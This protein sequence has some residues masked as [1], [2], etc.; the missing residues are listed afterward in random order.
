[1]KQVRIYTSDYE[2]NDFPEASHYPEYVAGRAVALL[3]ENG[4]A[5]EVDVEP[6]RPTRVFG[7]DDP[8]LAE[9]L[10][11][12]VNAEWWDDFCERGYLEYKAAP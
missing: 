5:A 3:V 1:M 10:V 11:R 2:S 6:G 9:D 7:I 8:D 4:I 12:F